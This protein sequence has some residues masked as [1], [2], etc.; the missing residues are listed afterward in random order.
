MTLKV[1][2]TGLV[3]LL[4]ALLLVRIFGNWA[5]CIVTLSFSQ[6]SGFYPFDRILQ[7]CLDRQ[8]FSFFVFR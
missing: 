6:L 2:A 3:I 1:A 7:E 8:L 5:D 4:V